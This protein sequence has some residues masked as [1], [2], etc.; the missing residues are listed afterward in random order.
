MFYIESFRNTFLSLLYLQGSLFGVTNALNIAIFENSP[1]VNYANRSKSGSITG[2]DISILNTFAHRHHLQLEYMQVNSSAREQL[3]HATN[4]Q[5]IMKDFPQIDIFAG[6]LEA[7]AF[8]EEYTRPYHYDHLTWC[9]GKNNTMPRWRNIFYV[10]SD[11]RV[12]LICLIM[13]ICVLGLAYIFQMFEHPQWDWNKI[14]INGLACFCGIPCMY[15]PK[16]NA[17]RVLFISVLFGCLIFITTFTAVLMNYARKVFYAHQIQ[18]V[19]E[20]INGDFTLAGDHFTFAEL[21]QQNRTYPPDLLEKF[22]FCED[23]DVCLNQIESNE[24]L[25]VAV[26]YE[27][28][29][30]SLLLLKSKIHC[31]DKNESIQEFAVRFLVRK[32][33]TFTNQLNDV[34]RFA[35]DNGLIVHWLEMN[36]MIPHFHDNPTV[37]SIYVDIQ[38][39]WIV[40]TSLIGFAVFVLIAERIIHRKS[41][42]INNGRFWFI[43]EILIHPDRQFLL[44]DLSY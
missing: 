16:N 20:M 12:W 42:E 14:V 32:N 40:F 9:V 8:A 25:A 23:I 19:S 30:S 18:T 6:G 29:R 38:A 27:H 43:A 17:N 33:F 4:I 36:R 1:F 22:Q 39:V 41:I 37:L 13:A 3:L 11:L 10:C 21:L 28:V 24:K 15:K 7:N 5:R 26:S 2:L 34:I 35:N 31:F 44:Y